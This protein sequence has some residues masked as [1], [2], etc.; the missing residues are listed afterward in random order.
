MKEFKL[1]LILIYSCQAQ[2]TVKEGLYYNI[3][4]LPLGVQVDV[5]NAVLT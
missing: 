3:F 2:T 1:V 4:I 5:W